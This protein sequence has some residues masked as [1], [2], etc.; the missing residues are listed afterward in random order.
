MRRFLLVIIKYVI[1]YALIFLYS[2]LLVK[3]RNEHSFLVKDKIFLLVGRSFYVHVVT[4][5]SIDQS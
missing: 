4:K 3:E 2:R 1:I 5:K